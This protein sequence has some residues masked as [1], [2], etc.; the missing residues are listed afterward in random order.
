MNL[1]ELDVKEVVFFS[2]FDE[3]FFSVPFTVLDQ[4]F[5]PRV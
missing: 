5:L 1:L 4:I 3:D 2:K